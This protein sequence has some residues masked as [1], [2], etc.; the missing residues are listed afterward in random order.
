MNRKR[1]AVS[2]QRLRNIIFEFNLGPDMCMYI[3]YAGVDEETQNLKFS[4]FVSVVDG[5]LHTPREF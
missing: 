1:S 5:K 4:L 3:V 2:I